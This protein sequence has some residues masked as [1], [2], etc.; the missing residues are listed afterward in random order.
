MRARVRV[1]A[2]VVSSRGSSSVNQSRL[3]SHRSMLLASSAVTADDGCRMYWA[4]K[5]VMVTRA[6]DGESTQSCELETLSSSRK[7]RSF[8][9]YQ[10]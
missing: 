2:S 3:P 9:G 1:G 10:L 8:R 6:R 5:G 4:S 7:G